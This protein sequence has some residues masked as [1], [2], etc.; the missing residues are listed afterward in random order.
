MYDHKRK[1]SKLVITTQPCQPRQDANT[2]ASRLAAGTLVYR[3]DRLARIEDIWDTVE[4]EPASTGYA[5]ASGPA[6]QNAISTAVTDDEAALEVTTTRGYRLITAPNTSVRTVE[7]A[8][9][10]HWTPAKDLQPEMLVPIRL[11]GLSGS[12]R[13][14]NLPEAPQKALSHG[15]ALDDTLLFRWPTRGVD[16]VIHRRRQLAQQ[17]TAIFNNDRR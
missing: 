16:R 1:E 2:S 14:I 15:S 8:G 17:G 4:A 9:S 11:G 12:P 7:I 6:R 13:T 5:T 3:H 10:W